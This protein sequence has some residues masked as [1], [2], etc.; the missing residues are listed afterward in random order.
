LGICAGAFYAGDSPYN[1][2]NLTAGTRFRFYSAERR[3]IRKVAVPIALADGTRS[4]T[5]GKTGRSSRVGARWSRSIPDGTPACA[6]GAVGKGWVVLSGVHPEAPERWRRGLGFKTPTST[7]NAYAATLIQA[8][9]N[10]TPLP[11]F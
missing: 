4:S 6:Q 11:Q 5:T 2:L 8:A 3:G 10:R 1:G 7:S 9:L